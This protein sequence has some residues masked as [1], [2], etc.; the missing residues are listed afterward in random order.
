[1]RILVV[2]KYFPDNLSTKVHGV[3]KRFRMFL[4]AIKEIA[5]I[6]LL[7]YVP[8]IT[9]T[10]PTSI[11]SL[12]RSFSAHFG[13][14]IR[15]SLSKR[16]SNT[17]LLSKLMSY[18]AGSFSLIRQPSYSGM[19]Q[20]RQVQALETCLRYNPDAIFMHRLGVMCPLL[21]TR[22]TLPPVF[23]DL[24]DIEHIAFRRMLRYSSKISTRLLNYFLI[25]ALCLGEYKAIKLAHRTFVCSDKD[26]HYLT[27]RWRLKGVV[28]IPNAV[29]IPKTQQITSEHTLLFLASYNHK[30]N[31]DAAEFFIQKIWP[32]V[33]R[34]KPTATMKIVGTPPDRIPSY[35]A[36]IQGVKFTGFVKEL[37]DLYRQSRVVCAPILSGG[38][39]RVKILEAAAY[40]KPIVSTRIGAEGIEMRDGIEIFLRDDPESFAKACIRLLNDNMLSTQMG[41]AARS[42]AIKKYNQVNVKQM[43]QKI[44]KESFS[45]LNCVQHHR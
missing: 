18:A 26:R 41:M 12:E 40:G 32:L 30:P 22:R 4:D 25:P 1:M 42:M 14:P 36:G 35:H 7:Y 3:H 9:D 27:N 39:T 28:K 5:E 34:E 29:K 44:I 43:I 31:I 24:D 8:D 45:N 21:Q 11:M 10:S 37:D 23:F 38:G 6:D 20:P 16:S 33:R 15:L 13:T 19:A 2:S 17:N